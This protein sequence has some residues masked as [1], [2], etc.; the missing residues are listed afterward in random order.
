VHIWIKKFIHKLL[1][2]QPKSGD[3]INKIKKGKFYSFSNNPSKL[4]I[5]DLD[6]CGTMYDSNWEEH[7]ER[8]EGLLAAMAKTQIKHSLETICVNKCGMN[9]EQVREMVDRHGFTNIGLI[10][11]NR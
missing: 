7:P 5:L 9:E 4:K 3:D 10:V 1:L 2:A 6:K 11:A 8:L